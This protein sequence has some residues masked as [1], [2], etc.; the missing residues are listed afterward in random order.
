MLG[1]KINTHKSEIYVFNTSPT[2]RSMIVNIMGF[3]LD[4]LPST[5]L[6]V[7][8][9][10]G[11]NKLGYWNR[12]IDRI[13]SRMAAWRLRWLSLSSRMIHYLML[14]GFLYVWASS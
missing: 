5:Y 8:F 13:K 3:T 2:I 11:S 7:P 12:V 4:D 14:F 10:T 6:G 1:Q 9:F